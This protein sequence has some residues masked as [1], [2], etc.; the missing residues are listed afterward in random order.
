VGTAEAAQIALYAVPDNPAAAMVA[1][2]RQRMN[3]T[4]KAVKGVGLVVHNDHEGL[5]VRIAANLARAHDTPPASCFRVQTQRLAAGFLRRGQRWCVLR[6][7]FDVGLER[8]ALYYS[9]HPRNDGVFL[10]SGANT[11]V[12]H[13]N[14]GN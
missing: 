8:I 1:P 4:L 14:H 6:S 12:P 11:E 3:G 7:Q 13:A 10:T 5:I 2:R 9:S